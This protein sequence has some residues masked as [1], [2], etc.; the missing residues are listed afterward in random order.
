MLL[1]CSGGRGRKL[2]RFLGNSSCLLIA[3]VAGSPNQ[4]LVVMLVSIVKG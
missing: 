1:H 2:D 4:L 3:L